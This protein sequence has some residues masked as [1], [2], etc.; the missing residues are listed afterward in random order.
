MLLIISY[1]I[2]KYIISLAKNVIFNTCEGILGNAS[3]KPTK[4]CTSLEDFCK[5]A[6]GFFF[7]LVHQNNMENVIQNHQTFFFPK[8]GKY[9]SKG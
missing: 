8:L 1:K 3:N 9:G 7:S 2:L 6:T 4:Y 5:K